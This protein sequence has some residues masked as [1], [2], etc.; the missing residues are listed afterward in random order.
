MSEFIGAGYHV[1][2]YTH[3]YAFPTQ[4]SSP[5]AA[6]VNDHHQRWWLEL[7]HLE[8]A[9]LLINQ[10]IYLVWQ[11]PLRPFRLPLCKLGDTYSILIQLGLHRNHMTKLVCTAIKSGLI[12]GFDESL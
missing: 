4:K 3:F 1:L 10:T 8:G 11:Q 12:S 9:I 5:K 2:R 6:L 7:M